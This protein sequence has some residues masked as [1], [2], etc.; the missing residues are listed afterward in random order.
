AQGQ[1]LGRVQIHQIILKSDNDVP[2]I[3]RNIYVPLDHSDGTNPMINPISPGHGIFIYR[4]H[5]SFLYPNAAHYTEEMVNQ[6]FC[7][8]KSGRA[9][10]YRSLGQQPW[11][12][13]TSRHPERDRHPN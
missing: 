4:I 5:E 13:Q 7:E 11:N 1:F 8:T 12:L 2:T 3:R 10:A 9:S 6:I